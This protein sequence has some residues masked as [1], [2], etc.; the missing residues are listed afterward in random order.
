MVRQDTWGCMVLDRAS[1]LVVAQ[2]AGP[3]EE[4]L[5]T[6]AITQAVLRLG[7]RACQWCSD[8][9]HAYGE[10][11][12]QVYRRKHFTGRPGRPAWVLPADLALTQVVKQ[13]D[14]HGRV[15]GVERQAVIG[16]LIAEASCAHVE[17]LH[18]SLRDHLAC[19]TR[20]THAFA[21]TQRT[22]QAAVGLAVFVH[23]WLR[24]H[25][26]LREPSDA[27]AGRRYRQRTPA[28]AVGLS[29]HCWSWHEFLTTPRSVS[30]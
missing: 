2:Q 16:P 29:E 5:L 8:G 7:G 12:R 13:H 10:L 26:S 21:K 15:V 9:W 27:V 6:R 23:N 1:R 30:R 11:L 22:W 14:A 24:D 3:L 19:L 20:K 25:P 4:R 28:M 18:G 17:R